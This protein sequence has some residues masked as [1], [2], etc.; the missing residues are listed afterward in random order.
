MASI[1]PGNDDDNDD[2]EEVDGKARSE[3]IAAGPTIN[4]ER[5]S[6]AAGGGDGIGN[7]YTVGFGEANDGTFVVASMTV[8]VLRRGSIRGR[9]RPPKLLTLTSASRPE[10]G[11]GKNNKAEMDRC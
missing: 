8:V 10:T 7:L 1:T 4:K 6:V 2:G 5:S 9:R 11:E 3:S